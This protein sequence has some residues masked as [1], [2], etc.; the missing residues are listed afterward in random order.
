LS[1]EFFSHNSELRA[2]IHTQSKGASSQAGKHRRTVLK[3]FASVK[4]KSTIT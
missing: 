1:G 2:Y 3:S 4:Q